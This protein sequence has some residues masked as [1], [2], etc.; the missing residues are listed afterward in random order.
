MKS[1]RLAPSSL[2]RRGPFSYSTFCAAGATAL[3]LTRCDTTDQL[4]DGTTSRPDSREVWRRTSL[5]FSFL[6]LSHSSHFWQLKWHNRDQTKIKYV[7]LNIT[8]TR[9][10]LYLQF[11]RWAAKVWAFRIMESTTPKKS[12]A[13][14]FIYLRIYLIPQQ[15]SAVTPT[16]RMIPTELILCAHAGK[17]RYYAH[18]VICKP[19]PLIYSRWR[20]NCIFSPLFWIY[21][22]L[23]WKSQPNFPNWHYITL[24]S[25]ICTLMFIS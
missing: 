9:K 4:M 12:A 20:K 2:P 17:E 8:R 18:R 7:F 25:C 16:V 19:Q 3:F 11:H 24:Q 22:W 15:F 13:I 23:V 5:A 21:L 14:E 1:Y 10:I 6:T